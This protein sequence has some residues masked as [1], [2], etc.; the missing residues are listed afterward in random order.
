M[1]QPL[2]I[3]SFNTFKNPLFS[4]WQKMQVLLDPIELENLL[5][6]LSPLFL[7]NISE[8]VPYEKISLSIETLVNTYQKY[9]DIVRGKIPKQ[10]INL[11]CAVSQRTDPFRVLAVTA[12]QYICRSLQP[13]VHLQ[14]YEFLLDAR[15]KILPQVFS[16]DAIS[17]GLQ[18]AY[19]AIF[20]DPYSMEVFQATRASFLG[21]KMFSAIRHWIRI[22]SAPLPIEI[23]GKIVYLPVRIGKKAA[24]WIQ[25]HIDRDTIAISEKGISQLCHKQTL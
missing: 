25:E 14:T 3:I 21:W 5:H 9:I 18:F 12:N 11:T 24:T 2:Q 23:Q 7:L 15:G 6:H 22:H 1:S 10:K 16:Q 8:V 4:K 19:P 20:Q 13:E 17:W